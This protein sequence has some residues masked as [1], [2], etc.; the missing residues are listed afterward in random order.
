M[1]KKL[2]EEKFSRHVLPVNMPRS[3]VRALARA[4]YRALARDSKSLSAGIILSNRL[5][6]LVATGS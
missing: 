3:R 5:N 4:L 1:Y 6:P 2:K